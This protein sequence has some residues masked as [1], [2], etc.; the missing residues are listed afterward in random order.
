[1]HEHRYYIGVEHDKIIYDDHL[2]YLIYI[3]NYKVL[4][5]QSKIKIVLEKLKINRKKTRKGIE[6]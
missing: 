5:N 1:M 6:K 4:K 3:T 2:T